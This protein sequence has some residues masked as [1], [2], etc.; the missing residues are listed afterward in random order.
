MNSRP[1]TPFNVPPPRTWDARLARRLVTPLINTRVTPNHLT[2]LRLLIGVAGALC[3]ARGGFAWA[4]AGAV[5]IVLSNFVDHTDGELARISGKSSRIGHFYDLACDA[6]VT[7]ML[8]IGMGVGA[9]ASNI[10]GLSVAPGW[11]GAVAGIAV[12][13][14]FFLR[15]RIEEMAGKAGTKQA[16]VGGFETEDVL[17]L[18]PIVTLTS[19]VMP[20]VVAA[21]IGAPLFA[22]WVMIDYWR[23]SRRTAQLAG[24]GAG[25]SETHQVVAGK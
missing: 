10:G 1:Q 9:G 21:S 24:T 25:A 20:F 8:F 4:N 6:L 18:L 12:A 3:L 13:L 2:T 5:L 14:I 17:Y 22:V 15:M 7:V 11:L 19:V 16:A 23:V